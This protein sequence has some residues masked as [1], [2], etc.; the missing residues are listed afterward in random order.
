VFIVNNSLERTAKRAFSFA[1]FNLVYVYFYCL[2]LL[3]CYNLSR[4]G[5]RKEL[6]DVVDRTLFRFKLESYVCRGN[7]DDPM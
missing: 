5:R 3:A 1:K 6:K 7:V 4:V 2:L